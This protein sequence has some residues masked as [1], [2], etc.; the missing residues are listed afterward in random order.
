[1][2]PDPWSVVS[3]GGTAPPAATPPPASDPW[4]VTHVDGQPTG[5]QRANKALTGEDETDPSWQSPY[6]GGMISGGLKS[7]SSLLGNVLDLISRKP[8]P[9]QPHLPLEAPVNEKARQHLQDAATWLKSGGEPTGF[10]QNVGSLGEQVLEYIGTDGLLKLAGG[11]VRAVEAGQ[12]GVR[13]AE[14]LKGAQDV[15]GVLAKHPKL[16]GLVAVGLKASKD[17]AMMSA[18]AY[19]H[20]EDPTQAAIAGVTG[21]GARVVTEGAAAGGRYLSSLRPKTV[22]IAGE[23]IPALRSQVNKSG[24]PNDS[25]AQGA[26]KIAEAQQEGAQKVIQN[27]AQQA[28][29]GSLERVNQ[30]RAAF[31]PTEDPERLLA[32]PEGSEPF[33]FSIQSGTEPIE[34]RTEMTVQPAKKFD[35]AASNVPEGAEPGAQNAEEMGST[36]KTIPD[37]MQKRTQAFTSETSEG[38]A[39]EARGGGQMQTQDPH[40]AESWLR[41]LEEIQQSPMHDRF[42]PAQQAQIEAQRQGLEE[43]LGLYHSSPYAQRFAP[44]DTAAAIGQVR[45][46]G[47][48]ATQIEAAAKPVYQEL[49]RVSN[50]DFAKWNG[51][52]K[53]AQNIIRSATSVEA[54]DRAEQ[55]LSEANQAIDE[56]ITRHGSQI[57]PGD[58]HT[59]KSAWRDA[60]R[61][62][63]LHS[64]FERMMNGI[65]A[66][67]SEQGFS[68]VMTGR[69]KL[70]AGYL[71]KGQ[72]QAEIERLIGKE[73]IRN[74][75][76]LTQLLSKANSARAT[77]EVLKNVALEIGRHAR[78][79]G[80]GGAIGGMLAHSMNVPWF[81]G[82]MAGATLTEGMRMVMRDASTNPRIGN[83]IDWAARN[84]LSPQHYGPLIARAI[85]VPLQEQGQGETDQPAGDEQPEKGAERR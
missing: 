64:V 21:A 51:A 42:T 52:A 34:G 36:A 39:D 74:L 35:P 30:T 33:T 80:L 20:T 22:T 15:A 83:M 59:A 70:L 53:Q 69:T 48:A 65:T 77:N 1:M 50:G 73:G 26:P 45:T 17:A 8:D 49:D 25:G 14:E 55:R 37:R 13:A 12:K 75:K 24:V 29:G 38:A 68:R 81:E 43:Q 5:M 72:N 40:E 79:G 31:T 67:E 82:M 4:A 2:T 11:P 32:A 63:E 27:V 76:Q 18:Q 7:A 54:V 6:V 58:F 46:F 78:V 47:D 85:T 66:E 56:L 28:A 61:L 62:N 44:I 3:V 23:E 10:W 60:S 84:G 41:Q 71:A 9:A 16:A 57:S 19:G